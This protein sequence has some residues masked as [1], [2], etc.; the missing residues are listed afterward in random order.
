METMV[1]GN[2]RRSW[3]V[4]TALT[5]IAPALPACDD[6]LSPY[7]RLDKLRVLAIQ[8]EPVDLRPGGAVTLTPLVYAP[9]GHGVTL[10][11]SWATCRPAGRT[12]AGWAPGPAPEAR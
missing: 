8:G 10:R 9:P 5:V 1:T 6:D 2:P 3:P 11:W 4:L 7:N 12:P